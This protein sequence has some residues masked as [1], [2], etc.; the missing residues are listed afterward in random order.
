MKLQIPIFKKKTKFFLIIPAI[1]TV[2]YLS[3]DYLLP[4]SSKSLA[5]DTNSQIPEKDILTINM[6]DIGHPPWDYEVSGVHTVETFSAAVHGSLAPVFD[7]GSNTHSNQN[8]LLEKYYCENQICSATLKKGVYFHNNREVNAY[9]VEFSLVKNLLTQ[10]GSSISNTILDDL[11]GIENMNPNDIQY[12]T[13]NSI[14]YPTKA[15][16]GIEVIDNYNIIFKLKRQNN[17]FFERISDGKL[18]IVP[19]EE[20][21]E[22]YIEWKK[23]PVG[24][25][26]YKVSSANVKLNEYYLQKVLENEKIPKYIKIIFGSENPG[27]IKLLLGGP[28]RGIADYE[29]VVIFSNIYSNAGFLYNYQ[30][31]LGKNEN[32]RKAISLALDRV[33]I[34]QNST[35]R[36]MQEEDQMLPNSGWQKEFRANI[37]IQKQNIPE[38]KRLLSL[39]PEHL[40]KN[41]IFEVPTFWEDVK[42]VNTLPYIK[43]IQKQLREVGIETVFL[44]T[45]MEYD[46]FRK[47]DQNVLFF[48]GF[49]FATKDPNRN[50]G[51]FRK[52]SYFTYEQPNDK[53]F[54]ELYQNSVKNIYFTNEDTKVLSK[55]FTEKN[56]MTIILNQ[57][58]S[59]SYDS[60]KVISLGNQYNG[61]RL[62]IWEIK[63]RE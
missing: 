39:V 26:K 44:N 47:D 24:F 20:Y 7:L 63:I 31:E 56:F 58:M 17:N 9:D 11:I 12:V 19:I 50:F 13:Y 45:D 15:L 5:E 43:E 41:I 40:W 51:H 49:G 52:G 10:N 46:K 16:K 21:K 22:N 32:F 28:D 27:D 38:A 29:R 35:F 55:Y 48:T 60:R 59:L 23:Y 42:E 53:K 33:K 37:E 3:Y 36:E 18:P 54:E 4:N 14:Q 2:T 30:S 1:L 57:R 25:G 6:A 62:A 34:A 8:V 61:I